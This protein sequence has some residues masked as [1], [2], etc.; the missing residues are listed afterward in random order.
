MNRAPTRQ[1]RTGKGWTNHISI[2]HETDKPSNKTTS[3]WFTHTKITFRDENDDKWHT[4]HVHSWQRSPVGTRA[5]LG[6]S[7]PL[8]PQPKIHTN[9]VSLQFTEPAHAATVNYRNPPWQTGQQVLGGGAAGFEHGVLQ[10][11]LSQRTWP[12]WWR[13]RTI[14]VRMKVTEKMGGQTVSRCQ[15]HHTVADITGIL[16][17]PPLGSMIVPDTRM[18]TACKR[19]SHHNALLSWCRQLK[20]LNIVSTPEHMFSRSDL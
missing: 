13:E 9:T 15:T 2:L 17:R 19:I 8:T 6:K 18:D 5:R 14:S 20:W 3:E 10:R 4:T 11:S 7:W 12:S 1:G 16:C